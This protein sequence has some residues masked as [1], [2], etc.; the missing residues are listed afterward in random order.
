MRAP[1]APLHSRQGDT[2]AFLDW[3]KSAPKQDGGG[4]RA[5]EL[6][7]QQRSYASVREPSELDDG[8]RSAPMEYAGPTPPLARGGAG[9]LA[10]ATAARRASAAVAFSAAVASDSPSSCD[11]D[12]VHLPRRVYDSG[13]S[14]ADP[15]ERGGGAPGARGGGKRGLQRA[16]SELIVPGGGG[17]AAAERAARAPL[18]RGQSERGGLDGAE[19]AARAPLK[20][21]QSERGGLDGAEP[22]S[23]APTKD[24]RKAM[25]R[26]VSEPQLQTPP[27]RS[28][29][30]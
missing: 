29:R 11:A 22:P 1:W 27:P 6:S 13:G 25:S 9:A 30:L 5:A 16:Q 24:K 4:G 21:G 14:L 26:G 7:A 2:S 28:R 15:G 17:A 3:S 23:R 8:A 10:L 12:G 20:R 18:K 19:R